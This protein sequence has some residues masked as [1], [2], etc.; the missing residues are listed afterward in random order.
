MVCAASA[1]ENLP[2]L[3]K[4]KKK[5]E[6]DVTPSVLL[7]FKENHAGSCA[8]E[9]KATNTNSIPEKAVL[10]HQKVALLNA[11]NGSLTHKIADTGRRLPFDAF[12]LQRVPAYVVACFTAHGVCKVIPIEQWKGARA[13]TWAPFEIKL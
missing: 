6:A 12:M 5:R 7:W 4:Q 8:I 9:V 2:N 10:P 3:P 1:V 11:Q 13:D